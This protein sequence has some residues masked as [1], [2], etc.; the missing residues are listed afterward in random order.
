MS[1]TRFSSSRIGDISNDLSG[2]NLRLSNLV[3]TRIASTSQFVKA[4]SFTKC[5]AVCRR[6]THRSD[7]PIHFLPKCPNGFDR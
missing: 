2:S 3:R 4:E 7:F 5:I 1:V 6:R